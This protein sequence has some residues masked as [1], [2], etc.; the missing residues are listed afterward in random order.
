MAYTHD[1]GNLPLLSPASSSRSPQ[2]PWNIASNAEFL[3]TRDETWQGL[4]CN[5]SNRE[6][7]VTSVADRGGKSNME[8][9]ER[10]RGGI[11]EAI[12]MNVM[13]GVGI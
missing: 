4:R 1:D 11:I 12:V 3:E 10:E 9:R 6:Y 8:Q 5:P 2:P 13:V 7:L